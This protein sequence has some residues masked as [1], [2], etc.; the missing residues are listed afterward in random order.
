MRRKPL[1]PNDKNNG[2][3]SVRNS[4]GPKESKRAQ[5]SPKKE[6]VNPWELWK[7]E[8]KQKRAKGAQRKD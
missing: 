1:S 6:V 7:M 2:L 4:K 5:E 8:S 3:G